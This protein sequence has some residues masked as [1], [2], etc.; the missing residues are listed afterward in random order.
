MKQAMVR[1]AI[2]AL[3]AGALVVVPALSHGD[4]TGAT[5]QPATAAG[6]S[7]GPFAGLARSSN[8]LGDLFGTRTA[9]SRYGL[10]LTATETSEVLGNVTGGTRRGAA[11][12]GLFQIDLQLDAQ[13][14]ARLRPALAPAQSK[15]FE[16]IAH[17]IE[18]RAIEIRHARVG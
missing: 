11:Y 2:F 14:V 4:D 18:H 7:G 1:I 6:Q 10:T 13:I 16:D 15:D 3:F 12:D 5:T 9:M 8:L 17:K